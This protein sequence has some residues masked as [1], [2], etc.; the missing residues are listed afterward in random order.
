MDK[1]EKGYKKSCNVKKIRYKG[2]VYKID[3][4]ALAK[5]SAQS[6][7][8]IILAGAA[9]VSV[10]GKAADNIDNFKNIQQVKS[11]YVQILEDNTHRTYDNKGYWYDYESMA[12]DLLQNPE[13]YGVQMYCIYD[14]IGLNK[15][16]KIECMNKLIEQI[17]F[18]ISK[19]PEKYQNFNTYKNFGYFLMDNGFLSTDEYEQNM[20]E[21]LELRANVKEGGSSW[22]K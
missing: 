13:D 5:F 15:E 12:K 17:N 21:V 7:L 8:A 6:A 14:R 20:E 10:A 19:N 4:K 1:Y 9:L 18:E 2:K 11:A 22:T 3:I 16:D